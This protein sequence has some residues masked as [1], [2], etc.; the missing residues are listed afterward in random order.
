MKSKA[1]IGVL[2][3]LIPFILKSQV[4]VDQDGDVAVK[5]S[6]FGGD[7]SLTV[8]NAENRIGILSWY[9]FSQD[10]VS[11]VNTYIRSTVNSNTTFKGV[12][13]LLTNEG[14]GGAQG[15]FNEV[16][17][18]N[19][20]S[21]TGFITYTRGFQAPKPDGTYNAKHGIMNYVYGAPNGETDSDDYRVGIYSKTISNGAGAV[22]GMDVRA[23]GEG[24]A[25][26]TGSFV[27]T[28]GAGNGARKGIDNRTTGSGDG[29]RIGIH[30]WSYGTGSGSRVGIVNYTYGFQGAKPDGTFNTKYGFMNYVY[31]DTGA[32]AA[33]DSDEIRVGQY[34]AVQGNGDGKRTGIIN[35]VRGEGDGVRTGMFNY[36]YQPGNGAR[37]GIDNRAA[38]DG[39]GAGIGLNN[40][41]YGEGSGSRKG[42]ANL[43]Y[44][45]VDAPYNSNNTKYGI[46]NSVYGAAT[47]SDEN[48]TGISHDVYGTGNGDRIGTRVT[49]R[50]DGDGTRK[51]IT[52]ASYGNGTGLRWGVATTVDG[53]GNGERTGYRTE[54]RGSGDGTR[55]GVYSVCQGS[56][57]GIRYGMQSLT[58]GSGDGTRE[59][60]RLSTFGSGT[61][62]RYG[63]RNYTYG[64]GANPYY[65]FFNFVYGNNGTATKYGIY[66]EVSAENSSTAYALY[67]RVN[68]SGFAGYFL[69]DVTVVGTFTNTP[70]DRRLK[71]DI[72][73]MDYGLENLMQLNP[74]TFYYNHP[75][76][77]LAKE[78]QL[79]LIAQEVEQS[80]PE[81]VRETSFSLP[82][83]DQA[84]VGED[85]DLKTETYKVIDYDKLVPI[86][87]KSIQEQQTLI[88]KQQAYIEQIELRLKKLEDGNK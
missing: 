48:R 47:D 58:Y 76:L 27:L 24:S 79:G 68:G 60:L 52:V 86:L 71:K 31:G 3:F 40:W 63:I 17:S 65:G 74:V 25:E 88:E 73:K 4:R 51:G 33:N 72:Q 9:N 19:Y 67:S 41:V 44:G 30:S 28:N 62:Y 78:K 38:L 39:T 46:I 54:M 29:G 18:T 45:F 5:T 7:V 85:I 20:G 75:S 23:E 43:V 15:I 8:D 16:M 56:G 50:G 81:V 57:A 70:S 36:V 2:F 83:P 10:G 66:N 12:H 84:E 42:I 37:Y 69:G 53:T 34:N 11:G 21:V 49:V 77:P 80:I 82:G 14:V 32:G 35:Y 61:G 59:G 55:T 13:H 87:I 64:T 6:D 26:R 1:L 22:R